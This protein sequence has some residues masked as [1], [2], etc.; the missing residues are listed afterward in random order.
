MSQEELDALQDD[1]DRFVGSPRPQI[2]N[3]STYKMKSGCGKLYITINERN[4]R[5]YEVFVQTAGS[6]GCQANSEAIGRLISICLRNNIPPNEII[7]QLR[8]V[9]CAAAIK[10]HC[11]GKSCADIIANCLKEYFDVDDSDIKPI[12]S[13]TYI[14]DIPLDKKEFEKFYKPGILTKEEANP[15][16]KCPECGEPI[17]LAEGCLTCQTCGWSKCK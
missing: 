4:G 9:K 12:S 3:G 6:G 13:S 2:L 8:R 15:K 7:K 14:P 11:D 16:E 10:N 5:P 1:Y 17:V